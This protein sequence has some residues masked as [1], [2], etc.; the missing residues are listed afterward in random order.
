MLRNVV[1]IVALVG[2]NLLLLNWY[3][4]EAH[5]L[6]TDGSGTVSNAEISGQSSGIIPGLDATESAAVRTL[7]DKNNDGKLSVEELEKC[8]QHV[9][10]Q[11][12]A[13]AAAEASADPNAKIPEATEA[14]IEAKSIY[15]RGVRALTKLKTYN[16][17]GLFEKITTQMRKHK[18]ASVIVVIVLLVPL[19]FAGALPRMDGFLDSV[20][21]TFS[22]VARALLRVEIICGCLPSIPLL[23]NLA[24]VSNVTRSF[25][26]SSSADP[27]LARTLSAT[28]S[29]SRPSLSSL[30]A[31][32]LPIFTVPFPQATPFCACAFACH[33]PPP[34][35]TPPTSLAAT[36]ILFIPHS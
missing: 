6:D 19:H 15:D 29:S 33:R 31:M 34:P 3:R 13:G 27:T 4:N 5:K 32:C 10:A 14:Q 11:A 9:A 1:L 21:S 28:S 30:Q 12:A 16:Y 8:F 20:E 26:S 24:R 22:K 2:I 36:P 23:H 18:V 7:C 25:R 35:L 17:R